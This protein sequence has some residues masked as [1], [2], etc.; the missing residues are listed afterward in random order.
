MDAAGRM[1]VYDKATLQ[2]HMERALKC[3]D[4]LDSVKSI[5]EVEDKDRPIQLLGLR[6]DTSLLR[7]MASAGGVLG[8]L[9]GKV[10]FG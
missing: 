5:L 3:C 9:L 4:M 6:A 10:L 2:A 8:S 7:N 1:A